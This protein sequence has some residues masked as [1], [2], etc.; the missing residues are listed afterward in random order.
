MTA[1][2]N[3]VTFKPENYI[4]NPSQLPVKTRMGGRFNNHR[5]V[6]YEN[7][8]EWL[9]LQDKPKER[10]SGYL[11]LE[12]SISAN[13]LEHVRAAKNRLAYLG[14]KEIALLSEYCGDTKTELMSLGFTISPNVFDE[15]ITISE[16]I[17]FTDDPASANGCVYKSKLC[18]FDTEKASFDRKVHPDINAYDPRFKEVFESLVLAVNRTKSE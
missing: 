8:T 11:Y 5:I 15:L 2:S 18:I 7:G 10:F 13:G 12:N 14:G 4:I 6:T 16:K 1:N 17:G 9:V 3:T